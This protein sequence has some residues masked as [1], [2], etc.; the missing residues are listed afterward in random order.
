MK[1]IEEKTVILN[2]IWP[3]KK[4]L[5]FVCWH[6]AINIWLTMENITRFLSHFRRIF[7][8][9]LLH[10]DWCHISYRQ[11]QQSV[12]RVW[13]KWR[14]PFSIVF[15]YNK[16]YIKIYI[17]NVSIMTLFNSSMRDE[18]VKIVLYTKFDTTRYLFY[19]NDIVYIFAVR[20]MTM[21]SRNSI[22]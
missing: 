5:P 13:S 19:M 21:S 11:L 15:T 18:I 17:T 9:L 12:I 6:S 7:T 1:I 8:I 22:P 4:L 2:D 14:A 20:F 10:I 16:I 3:S